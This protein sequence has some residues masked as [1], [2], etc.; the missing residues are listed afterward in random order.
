M[1][2][3]FMIFLLVLLCGCQVKSKK[4][5]AMDLYNQQDYSNAI[6][7]F[8]DLLDDNEDEDIYYYLIKAYIA[9]G[10]YSNALENYNKAIT[11]EDKLVVDNLEDFKNE[12]ES[13]NVTDVE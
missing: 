8:N 7:W 13:I 5:M 3:G 6:I 9:K 2:K 12:I 10:D 4:E 1:K 11:K